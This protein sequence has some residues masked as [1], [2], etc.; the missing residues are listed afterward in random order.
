MF[1]NPD[2]VKAKGRICFSIFVCRSNFETWIIAEWSRWLAY[3]F[4]LV[5]VTGSSPVS[6]T[7][8]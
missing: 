1:H 2:L 4:D 6:A 7:N 3:H 5:G 8:I